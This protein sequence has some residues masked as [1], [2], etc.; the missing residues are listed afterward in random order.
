MTSCQ[1]GLRVLAVGL[2]CALLTQPSA[3]QLSNP[4]LVNP[5]G[6]TPQVIPKY[7]ERGVAMVIIPN[8]GG[9]FG[10]S[11]GSG[12]SDP[13]LSNQGASSGD[14]M[15]VLMQQNYGQ[16]AAATAQQLG[17]NAESIAGIAQAESNFR[18]IPTANGSSSATGPWQFT[19]GTFN[20][21]SSQYGLNGQITDPAAQA[22]A[23][24]YLLRDTAQAIGA[25][26]QQPVT[27]VQAYGGWVFGPTPGGQIA[28][29][30]FD[31]PL[32]AIVSAKALSNNGMGGW[33][34]GQFQQFAAGRLGPA[35]NQIVLN[36]T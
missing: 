25:Q 3:A 2:C 18:N 30:S 36:G 10:G 7:P 1:V 23:A 12:G 19:T 26:T 4:T 29:A 6:T 32:S 24:A 11:Y 14:P 5:S 21:V 31:T 16:I 33:S 35:A 28:T 22:T 17:V 20:A 9:S 15:A 34:V 8:N 27:T 13:S